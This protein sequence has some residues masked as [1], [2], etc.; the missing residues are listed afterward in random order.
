[1][2]GQVN[3]IFKFIV[4][5]V[6]GN[7]LDIKED[8]LEQISGL[9]SIFPQSFI[10]EKSLYTSTEGKQAF[11]PQSIEKGVVSKEER[12]RRIQELKEKNRNRM[13]KENIDKYVLQVLGDRKTMSS[14]MLP[15]KEMNDFKRTYTV[16]QTNEGYKLVNV[17][18]D[19]RN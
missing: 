5:M 13:S 15:L 2:S 8:T 4:T 3:E 17:L 11:V 19:F 7:N 18:E 16:I 6:E 14:A 12:E 1:M 10:D 9:F